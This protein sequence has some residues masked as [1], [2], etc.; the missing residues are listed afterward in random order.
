MDE[1]KR[2]AGVAAIE[3]F[4]R[5]GMVVG[6]GTG[7]TANH[8][9][10]ALARKLSSGELKDVRGVATSAV[11]RAKAEGLNIPLLEVGELITEVDG[12]STLITV[13][14]AIDGADEVHE[15]Q[16]V[17]LPLTLARLTGCLDMYTNKVPPH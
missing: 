11:T 4:V 7:S 1:L 12:R 2:E 5:D 9:I 6:L 16:P 3:E 8:A 10:E 17:A 13:D 14:V 15:S